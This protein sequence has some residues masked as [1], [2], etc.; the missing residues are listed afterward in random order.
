MSVAAEL[1]SHPTFVQLP[2]HVKP[3]WLR[4]VKAFPAAWLEE[5]ASNEVF[6]DKS[7]CLERLQA[8]AFIQGFAVVQGR[9]W[10]D[11]TH[12]WQFKCLLHGT[13]TQNRRGLDGR[14][15]KDKAGKIVSNRKRNTMIKVKKDCQ[16][17]YLLSHKA[18]SRGVEEK[19]FIG[20]AKCLI[21]THAIYLIPFSFKVH[22]K[23]ITEYQM[24]IKQAKKYRFGKITYTES[25]ELLKQE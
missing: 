24:L 18:V 21:H 22:E 7:H 19:H 20:T 5:P 23:I 11:R 15:E 3:V 25:Q 10:T 4:H 14:A 1:E 16:F 6:N 8:W 13:E 17:E 12:R 2:K 9:V